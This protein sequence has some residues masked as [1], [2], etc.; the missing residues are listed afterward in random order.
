MSE[1]VTM[2]S[3][4]AAHGC[5]GGETR[6]HKVVASHC[7]GLTRRFSTKEERREAL[8]QYRDQLKKELT[9][10]EEHLQELG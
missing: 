9:G 3:V 6:S 1:E 7:C 2:E 8:E 10:V 4:H 5:C